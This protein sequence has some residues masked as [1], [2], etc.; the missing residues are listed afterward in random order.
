MIRP[1]QCPLWPRKAGITG[2]LALIKWT[3]S[4]FVPYYF[5]TGF[6][7]F[8]KKTIFAPTK[9]KPMDDYHSRL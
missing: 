2:P 9:S 5:Y 6:M 1:S 7:I 8:I 3:D 4:N